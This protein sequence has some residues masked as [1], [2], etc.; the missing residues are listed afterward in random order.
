M[1]KFASSSTNKLLIKYS[2]KVVIITVISLLLFSLLFS[3]LVYKFDLELDYNNLFSIITV[4]LSSASISFISVYSI[5]N[6]GALMGVL[7]QLLLIVFCVINL[8]INENSFLLFLI[9]AVISL[10]TGALFG[11]IATKKSSRFKVK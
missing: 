10:A 4:F 7:S 5:K 9:K 2:V 11:I 8:I 6:N 3:W 1:K